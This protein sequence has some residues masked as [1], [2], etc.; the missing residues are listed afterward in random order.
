MTRLVSQAASN[1]PGRRPPGLVCEHPDCGHDGL[2]RAPKSPRRLNEYFWFCLD[3]VRAYNRSWN[4][5]E[6]MAEPEIESA[7]R[8]A[9]CWER[10]T[11][12]LGQRRRYWDIADGLEAAIGRF[13]DGPASGDR[14]AG[15]PPSGPN[16]ADSKALKMLGLVRPV[17]WAAVRARYKQLVKRLHPDA[18]GGDKSAEERLKLVNQAY[19]TLKSR[20][21]S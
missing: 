16:S 3:H 14:P 13:G 21:R 10:P 4:Y 17:S 18:N 8:S 1:D 11:W 19:S 5:C 20:A 12:P 2:Y 6:G 9:T 7:I 15:A